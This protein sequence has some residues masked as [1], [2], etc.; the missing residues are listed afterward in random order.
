M[1]QSCFEQ[2][3]VIGRSRAITTAL[4]VPLGDRRDVTFKEDSVRTQK[5]GGQILSLLRTMSMEI[6]KQLSPGNMKKAIEKFANK[7][8]YLLQRLAQWGFV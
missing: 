3:A 8:Q 1:G 6:V 2:F 5:Q 4:R 7:P